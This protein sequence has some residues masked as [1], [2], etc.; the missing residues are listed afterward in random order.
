V[1]FYELL[2]ELRRIRNRNDFERNDRNAFSNARKI[3]AEQALEVTIRAMATKYSR[4]RNDQGYVA[5]FTLP[6]NA[7]FN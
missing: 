3:K 6:W 5:D 7:H 2:D 4:P 1:A